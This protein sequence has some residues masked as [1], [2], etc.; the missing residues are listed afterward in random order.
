M[1]SWKKLLCAAMWEGTLVC[2]T[3]R[4]Q[5]LPNLIQSLQAPGYKAKHSHS[6]SPISHTDQSKCYEIW[7][8][9]QKAKSVLR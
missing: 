9:S 7:R 6:T 2:V 5:K 8:M 3:E 1:D 4:V